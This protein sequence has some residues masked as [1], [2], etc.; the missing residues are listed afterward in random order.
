MRLRTACLALLALS[1][2]TTAGCSTQESSP[3]PGVS[4][5]GGGL[6]ALIYPAVP[7]ISGIYNGTVVES[8]Q[9]KSIKEPLKITIRQSGSKFTGIFDIILKTISDEFPIEKGSVV[10]SRGKTIL[11]FTIEGSPGRNAKA[12]ATLVGTTITGRAK[13]PPHNGPA[14]RFKYSAKKE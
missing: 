13:V 10:V 8:S 12:T 6:P 1:A 14:V 4:A 3:M 5:G 11:H 2:L 9:G 7:N